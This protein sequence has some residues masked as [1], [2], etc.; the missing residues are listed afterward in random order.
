MNSSFRS[1]GHAPRGGAG[2]R[3]QTRT[4]TASR[5]LLLAFGAAMAA[6]P[7]A[8][9]ERDEDA[10][11]AVAGA[12]VVLMQRYV[13]SATRIEKNPWRYGSVPGF[14]VLTRASEYDTNWR[15]DA[16]RRGMW[17]EG[18]VM[19]KD[20]LPDPA[21]PYTVIL[22]DTD[23]R[24]VP[25]GE[26]HL[27]PTV[28][29]SPADALTW[30]SLSENTN[31]S[32]E[33][34]GSGDGDTLAI[35]NNLYG[36]ETAALMDSTISLER[37]GRC[38]PP[39]PAW[40]ISGLIGRTSGVFREAFALLADTGNGAFDR[41]GFVRGAAGPGTLWVSLA[42][43]QRM[44][45]LLWHNAHD[46]SITVPPL[47]LLFA[48]AAPPAE[49][50]ALWESEAAL[51]ARWGLM[52]EDGPDSENRRAFLEFVRRA[53]RAPVTEEMFKGCFGCG[54]EPMEVKLATFVAWDMPPGAQ[55]PVRLS[56][57]T[58]D[59]IGRILGDWLRMQ[60]DYEG[61]TDPEVGDRLLGL[62]GRML[63]RAYREDNGLPPDVAPPGGGEHAAA[64]SQISTLGPA[65]A[66]KPFVVTAERIHDPRLLAVYGL[67]A[68]DKGD[69]AKAR[70]LLDAA[71]K[72][73]V[74]RPRA[75]AVL[76]QLR[77]AEA[78]GK[79]LGADGKLSAAQAASVLEP[80]KAALAGAPKPDHYDL[81]VETWTNCEAKPA[82]GDIEVLR[83]GLERYPAD[84]DLAY[85][86]A[87]LCAQSGY[88]AQTSWFIDKGL[89]F[90][91]HEI[92]R[93]YFEQLRSTL[94]SPPTP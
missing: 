12:R 22:D 72:S 15:I 36:V 83:A 86:A 78:I 7:F 9:A 81:I 5:A 70:E 90:A 62:A 94:N 60:G 46:P 37:L 10:T 75:Y 57:A 3:G 85:N 1:G 71:A 24:E 59:Q 31:L 67:Y 17:I 41:P 47:R 87:E 77:Y 29:G 6:F 11:A 63:E 32:I 42:E 53:Q 35:N 25:A 55:E 48:K 56:E 80:L 23:L 34:V 88:A 28:L 65:V 33:T 39:L 43:T 45:K 2:F 20:W 19:P 93:E 49:R 89:V 66:M 91:T 13:V 76:A 68:H 69:D 64:S 51:F 84:T 8:R 27:K 79:P 92:N 21:V 38:T 82:E 16:L 40:L 14:E 58:S 4:L 26:I 74:S 18:R 61:G 54:Y 30:G 50:L 73:G 44:L 52:G